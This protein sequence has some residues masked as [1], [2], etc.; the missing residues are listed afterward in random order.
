M[1][2]PVSVRIKS[3]CVF[4]VTTAHVTTSSAFVSSFSFCCVF[5][6]VISAFRLDVVSLSCKYKSQPSKL[7][8]RRFFP[9]SSSE[10]RGCN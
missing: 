7:Y 6:E 3:I 9:S 4:I 10:D 2:D 8:L 1:N 5:Q